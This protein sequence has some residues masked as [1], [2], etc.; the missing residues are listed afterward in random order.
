MW[1]DQKVENHWSTLL[2]LHSFTHVQF[3]WD[4]EFGLNASDDAGI[5]LPFSARLGGRLGSYWVL[6]LSILKTDIVRL[7]KLYHLSQPNKYPLNTYL[8][9]WFYSFRES[10]L[11][12]LGFHLCYR[13]GTGSFAN[14]VPVVH[15]NTSKLS[16]SL[17]HAEFSPFIF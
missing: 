9:Y 3:L 5:L 13:Y 12:H 10:W 14:I 8:F 17:W 4:S 15:R 16:S 7:P 2:L 11:V 1:P 6:S